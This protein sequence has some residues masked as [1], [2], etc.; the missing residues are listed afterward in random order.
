MQFGITK[1]EKFIYEGGRWHKVFIFLI[2]INIVVYF[3]LGVALS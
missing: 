2:L 1:T 3:S